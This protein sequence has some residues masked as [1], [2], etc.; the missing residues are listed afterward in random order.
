MTQTNV[1]SQ[2]HNYFINQIHQLLDWEL[3]PLKIMITYAATHEKLFNKIPMIMTMVPDEYKDQ[4]VQQFKNT[5]SVKF[6]PE[7]AEWLE[8]HYKRINNNTYY[9]CEEFQKSLCE[10]QHR[11]ACLDAHLAVQAEN[12]KQLYNRTSTLKKRPNM[13]RCF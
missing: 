6:G 3:N 8:K 13:F 2:M 11:Q 10:H 1:P 4:I 7:E 5:V 9:V 12:V